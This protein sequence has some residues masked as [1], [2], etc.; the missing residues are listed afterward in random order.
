[1]A[2]KRR[3]A[4]VRGENPTRDKILSTARELFYQQGIRAVGVDTII[5]RA[6]IAKTSLYRW[7]TTKDDLIAAFLSEENADFWAQWDKVAAK[8]PGAARTELSDQLKWIRAYIGSPRFR[9]CPF[10]N[11]TAEFPEAA[12]PG[13]VVCRAHKAELRRRLL[14]LVEQ[15][16]VCQPESLADQLVLLIDG[17][18]ASCQVLG[19]SGPARLLEDAAAALIGAAP[20]LRARD[21]R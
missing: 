10:L 20:K 8:H 16:G 1:V 18:F 11:A 14:A 21:A 7:F 4:G 19:K 17:A 6:A 5:A 2:T 9:G 3:T 13:R 15:L 12:H